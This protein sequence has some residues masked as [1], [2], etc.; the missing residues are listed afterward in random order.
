MQRARPNILLIT[1]DQQRRD[2]LG[3]YNSR[4]STP[5]VDSLARDGIVFDRAYTCHATCT[6]ARASIL[7]GLLGSRHGAYTI[8]TALPE[9]IPTLAGILS[10]SGYRTAL[11]GKPHFQ[12][13]STPGTLEYSGT[14]AD[15]DFW[16]GYEGGY[17]GFDHTRIY[18]GH[19]SYKF[20]AGMHYRVWLK[21]K[22]ITDRQ[23]NEWFNYKPAD[24]YREAGRWQLPREYHPSVFT[25]ECAREFLENA[26]A[27][28]PFFLW[29]SFSDP[30]DPHVTPAPYDTMFDPG[31]VDYLG[32]RPGEHD[33]RP[34]CYNQLYHGGVETLPFNDKFGVPSAPS[35]KLF[36]D[37]DYFRR[38]TA[39]HHGMVKLMG[40]EIEKILHTLHRKGLYDNTLILFT[41]DHGDYLGNH[42]FVYKGFPAFEEVYNIP[43]VIKPPEGCA[44][45][46]SDAL[47]SHIDIAPT[48]LDYAGVSVG[49]PLD[50]ISQRC[51]LETGSA[52]RTS[53]LI[54]NRLV[55]DGFYQKMLVTQKYKLVV[56]Q[57]STEGELY[58]LEADRNQYQNLWQ[59]PAYSAV[60]LELLQQLAS[61][62]AQTLQQALELIWQQMHAEELVQ[63]RTSYS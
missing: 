40:E 54:E 57:D 15:E 32:Y 21:D 26:D 13:L 6:P 22:G 20:T 55:T 27:D 59:T 10:H 25:G 34:A 44:C 11:V 38:I 53:L 4:L 7:T 23:I 16:R 63:I 30:H 24:S 37:D 12:Q 46:R 5:G 29:A 2:S 17:Y 43:L 3:C 56:Y 1:S 58:D 50:G 18:N 45:R 8:G 36:G 19:T 42:G 31:E 14:S 60:R 9:S 61:Q 51:T 47:F 52:A 49:H 39:L 41:T 28:R 35:A 62:K 48:A 33:Q